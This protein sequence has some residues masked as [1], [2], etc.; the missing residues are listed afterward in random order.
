MQMLSLA[1]GVPP[2]EVTELILAA[3]LLLTSPSISP[4]FVRS[5]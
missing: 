4:D 5:V 1:L 2:G 3:D